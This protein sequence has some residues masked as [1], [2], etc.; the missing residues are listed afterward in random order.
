MGKNKKKKG[1]GKGTGGETGEKGTMAL[2]V[3][4]SF[5][6]SQHMGPLLDLPVTTGKLGGRTLLDSPAARKKA[7]LDSPPSSDKDSLDPSLSP[8][9]EAG[10]ETLLDLAHLATTEAA[11]LDIASLS[12]AP[13]PTWESLLDQSLEEDRK[14]QEGLQTNLTPM[15]QGA[16]RVMSSRENTTPMLILG[17]A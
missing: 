12:I 10:G 17:D 5:R 1:K 16:T 6:R 8:L 9:P 2:E 7:L 15:Q 11:I 4:N 13:A 3:L 14:E